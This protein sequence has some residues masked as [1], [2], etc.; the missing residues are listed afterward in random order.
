MDRYRVLI[1]GSRDWRID[2][3]AEVIVTRLLVR[4]G[5]TLLIVHGD[6]PTGVDASFRE[7]CKTVGVDQEPHPARWDDIHC[8]GAVVR[9]R[10]DGTSYNANAG[11]IRNSAMV[12]LGADV[13]LA[14]SRNLAQ[15]RG[16][17]DCVG[18]AI[19]TGIPTWLVAEDRGPET[20]PVR[21]EEV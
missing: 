7:A 1:T 17:R 13:C 14:F 21:L 10:R 9:K 11:P 8:S 5:P 3:L 12:A 16:T 2:D 19:R 15:S 6:C 20:R 4:Y 18:K